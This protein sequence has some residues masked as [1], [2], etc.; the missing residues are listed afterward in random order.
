[1]CDVILLLIC[2]F[3]GFGVVSFECWGGGCL[4]FVDYFF[5]CVFIIGFC[6]FG[7]VCLVG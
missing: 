1:M 6:G 5:G 3:W 4:L 2:G 7:F